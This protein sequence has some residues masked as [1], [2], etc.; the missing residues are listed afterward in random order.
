MPAHSRS[1]TK[2]AIG[3]EKEE[4]EEEERKKERKKVH[5]TLLY[6]VYLSQ[7]AK[8]NTDNSLVGSSSG[9][10]G[11]LLGLLDGNGV[12]LER[13]ETKNNEN[14]RKRRR[15]RPKALKD[16]REEEGG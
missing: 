7:L 10:S 12:H 14:N 15:S 6:R 9:G 1:I 2:V 16:E 8:T 11:S 5:K 3:T 13:E 4:E